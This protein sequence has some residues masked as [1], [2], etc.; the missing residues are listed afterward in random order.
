MPFFRKAKNVDCKSSGS[1][2]A[3][4]VLKRQHEIQLPFTNG[5]LGINFAKIEQVCS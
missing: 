3:V 2:C 1:M 5:N 4:D